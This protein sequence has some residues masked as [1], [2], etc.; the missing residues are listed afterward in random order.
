MSAP[1]VYWSNQKSRSQIDAVT[2]DDDYTCPKCHYVGHLVL[3]RL[4]VKRSAYSVVSVRGWHEDGGFLTCPACGHRAK[5]LSNRKYSAIPKIDS[6]P[7]YVRAL[8]EV[9]SAVKRHISA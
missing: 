6:G 4:E 7:E 8:D 9:E 3:L 2:S 5:Q 1:V